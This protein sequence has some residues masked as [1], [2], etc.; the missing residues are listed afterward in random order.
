M[1]LLWGLAFAA[2]AAWAPSARAGTLGT[3]APIRPQAESKA[4]THSA[5]SAYILHCAGC[6]GMDGAGV[7]QAQVPD[8]RDMAAFLAVAGGR[9]FLIK[10]PGVMGS[11][12]SDE[13]IADV[14]NW[15][16]RVL[17]APRADAQFQPY[18]A[19][20]VRQARRNPL[21]DVM[22]TRQELVRQI[23]QAASKP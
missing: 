14:T 21:R 11:A 22:Q 12:L 13:D 19:Q 10:V 4:R 18:T 23:G 2:C 8:L 5:R 3:M 20:E 6:H 7:S 9:E 16:L 15:L 17:A 1:K